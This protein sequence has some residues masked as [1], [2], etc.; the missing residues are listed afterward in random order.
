MKCTVKQIDQAGIAKSLIAALK[1][2]GIPMATRIEALK[3][4]NA[5]PGNSAYDV[6][7][8]NIFFWDDDLNDAVVEDKELWDVDKAYNALLNP[9]FNIG[10]QDLITRAVSSRLRRIHGINPGQDKLLPP[11]EI[12]QEIVKHRSVKPSIYDHIFTKVAGVTFNGRQSLINH[13]Q[14]GQMLELRREPL[15]PFDPNAIAILT[16]GNQIG[17]INKDLAQQLSA[18]MDA[19]IKYKCQIRSVTGG[20]DLNFGINIGIFKLNESRGM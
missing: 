6:E 17:Y 8:Q 16:N 15:N 19:G 3:K 13:L 9:V 5:V 14:N 11:Y 4:L 10:K 1:D 7:V 20:G 12:Q 2:R 18:S